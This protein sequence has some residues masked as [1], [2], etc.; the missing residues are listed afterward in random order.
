MDILF[1]ERLI[2]RPFTIS[3]I[4]AVHEFGSNPEVVKYMLFGPNTYDESI[5]FVN[6]AI[7]KYK[8]DPIKKIDYVIEYNTQVVGA[9]SLHLKGDLNEA[10]MGWI[11]NPKF[12]NMGIATEAAIKF[13]EYAIT[14]LGINRLY[15]VCDARNKTSENVMKKLGMVLCSIQENVESLRKDG[16]YIRDQLVYELII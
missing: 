14:K 4:D 2:L 3:D 7:D 15:A 10:A 13:K 6:R 9:I 8:E 1:T 11:L 12:Q 5:E 16:L